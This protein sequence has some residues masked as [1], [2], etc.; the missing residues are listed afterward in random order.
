[1]MSIMSRFSFTPIMSFIYSFFI[2]YIY[3]Y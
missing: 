2:L 1:V 3:I